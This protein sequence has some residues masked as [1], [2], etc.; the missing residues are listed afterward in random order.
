MR[1]IDPYSYHC[2][3]MDSFCEIV[4]AGVKPMALSHPFA[5]P[6]ERARRRCQELELR[7]TPEPYEK[8]LADIQ[9]RD[10]N[11]THRAAAPLRPAAD[12]V[13]VDTTGFTFDDAFALLLSTIRARLGQ[14]G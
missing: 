10:Y 12:A 11:D 4:G 7:G 1:P 8:V 5:S 9:R 6:E 3:V 13:T 2:G 14:E